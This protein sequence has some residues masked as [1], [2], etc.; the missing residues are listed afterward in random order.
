VIVALSFTLAHRESILLGL[1]LKGADETKRKH[2]GYLGRYPDGYLS[3]ED[4]HTTRKTYVKR[5]H[6]LEQDPECA[7]FW[8]LAEKRDGE[9]NIQPYSW[10]FEWGLRVWAL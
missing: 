5:G 3:V 8:R 7:P 6:P 10:M 1:R 9:S 2:G 4:E